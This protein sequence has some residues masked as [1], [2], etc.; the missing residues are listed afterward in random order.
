MKSQWQPYRESLWVTLARTGT[1]AAVVGGV[2]TTRSG[3]GVGRWEL[4]TVLMLWPA[5]GGHWVEVWFLNWLRPR[6]NRG[7]GVQL[8]VRVAV[9][10]IGGIAL[11]T[12]M[13]ATARVM[14]QF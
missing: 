13:C 10:F 12:A 11:W 1:I 3:G 2:I 8:G 14:G 6:L 5:L 4:A 7:R 9:W